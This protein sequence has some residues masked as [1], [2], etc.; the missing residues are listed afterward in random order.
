[1]KKLSLLVVVAAMSLASCNVLQDAV[2]CLC[3][4]RSGNPKLDSFFA[5]A[6]QLQS[7]ALRVDGKV[8]QAREDLAVALGLPANASDDDLGTAYCEMFNVVDFD[9]QD[10][11]CYVDVN[12]AVTAAA[13]CQ[14]S[15]TP[16]QFDVLC[17]GTCHGTCR[18]GFIGK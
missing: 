14:V 16:G 17:Q 2:D 4:T 12:V 7:A 18:A 13:E 3:S 15:V 5:T 11:V 9:W 10:P 8:E 6:E 1:M